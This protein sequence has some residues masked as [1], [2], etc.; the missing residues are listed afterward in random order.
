MFQKLSLNGSVE[1]VMVSW[2]SLSFGK[3]RLRLHSVSYPHYERARRKITANGVTPDMP[4]HM[5][6]L[7]SSSSTETGVLID[8]NQAMA[9][10]LQKKVRTITSG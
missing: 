3:G 8:Y 1:S 4:R 9:P 6:S 2:Q 10:P 5:G 7:N